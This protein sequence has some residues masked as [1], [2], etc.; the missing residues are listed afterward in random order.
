MEQ[1]IMKL[2]TKI[3]GDTIPQAVSYPN[4]P[5]GSEITQVKPHG[6]ANKNKATL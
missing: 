6:T 1:I 2:G 5:T 4:I 3:A